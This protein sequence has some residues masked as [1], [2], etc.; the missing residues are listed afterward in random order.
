MR[1]IIIDTNIYSAFKRNSPAVVQALRAVDEVGIDV[2][3]LAELYAGFGLGS[4]G[5]KNTRELV[6]FLNNERVVLY[7]HDEMTSEFYAHI[8]IQLRR[9]GLPI[10]SNDMW[11][12]AVCLQHGRALYTLDT[13]FGSVKG[14]VLHQPII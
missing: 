2:T 7:P 8:F 13:H 3:V 10:P 6:E 11:I 12:A 14:L 4:R 9:E 5:Q 1:K